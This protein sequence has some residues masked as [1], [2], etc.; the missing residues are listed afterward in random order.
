MQVVER[1]AK[2]PVWVRARA[3]TDEIL[4]FW[5]GVMRD[6]EAAT[7]VRVQVS[8][9]LME[10]AWGKAPIVVAGDEERPI[11][12]DMRVMDARHLEAI[13]SALRVA[14]GEQVHRAALGHT[15]AIDVTPLSQD[16][17]DARGGGEGD[18]STGDASESVSDSN[19]LAGGEG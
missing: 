10:R 15:Q 19:G 16:Q 18:T 12:I 2:I 7:G 9:L 4:K 13:E 8:Q 11:A 1:E 14:I 17:G 5:V 3:Y 6:K